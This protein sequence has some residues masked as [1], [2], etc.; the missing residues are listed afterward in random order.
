[1][2]KPFPNEILD[3][4]LEFVFKEHY[5]IALK[6]AQCSKGLRDYIL[7]HR[8]WKRFITT[9]D[10]S[11]KYFRFK[12]SSRNYVNFLH[13]LT[14]SVYC[15]DCH[16]IKKMSTTIRLYLY[17]GY[18]HG[19]FMKTFFCQ[20]CG[21]KRLQHYKYYNLHHSTNLM[22]KKVAKHEFK[23]Q[24]QYIDTLPSTKVII[25]KNTFYEVVY[26]EH[27]KTLA[28]IIYG[29]KYRDIILHIRQKNTKARQD[30]KNKELIKKQKI[31]QNNM[32]IIEETINRAIIYPFKKAYEIYNEIDNNDCFSRP[33]VEMYIQQKYIYPDW[34]DMCVYNFQK[35]IRSLKMNIYNPEYTIRQIIRIYKLWDLSSIWEC[36]KM[37]YRLC[38]LT[39]YITDE[40]LHLSLL[41]MQYSEIT[42]NE[43]KE[44]LYWF[45]T[46]GFE[47]PFKYTIYNARSEEIQNARRNICQHYVDENCFLPSPR[48]TFHLIRT[49]GN[50][51][52]DPSNY[53]YD[54]DNDNDQ[55]QFVNVNSNVYSDDIC[56]IAKSHNIPPKSL[57]ALIEIVILDSIV[58]RFFKVKRFYNTASEDDEFNND[59]DEAVIHLNKHMKKFKIFTTNGDEDKYFL[60]RF[61]SNLMDL[62]SAMYRCMF[63]FQNACNDHYTFLHSRGLF[64]YF[65][66]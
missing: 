15:Y 1:M 66:Y 47:F 64:Y 39:H 9:E 3:L 63:P 40:Q 26:V 10:D 52:Y 55:D 21:L 5:T 19:S 14:E 37:A 28:T 36:I 33:K 27:L 42:E 7:N 41:G 51:D 32:N 6:L 8:Y 17:P 25:G 59:F 13:N 56:A 16:M 58:P 31:K 20:E 57:H 54:V 2:L 62:E 30:A 29:L 45:E 50:I 22:T 44:E 11:Q 23:L 61:S 46:Q 53:I 24:Q 4:I 18:E 65:H 43:I 34:I 49:F 12:D 35:R 38:D 48:L 60:I